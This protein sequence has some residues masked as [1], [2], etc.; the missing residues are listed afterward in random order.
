MLGYNQTVLIGD[1]SLYS[2]T[3]IAV[4]KLLLICIEE[5]RGYNK[6][7]HVISSIL[8]GSCLLVNDDQSPPEVNE[9]FGL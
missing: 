1:I 2:A 4:I 8:S 3:L 5:L 7:L 6:N 9:N